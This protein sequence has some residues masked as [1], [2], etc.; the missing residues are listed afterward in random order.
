MS[1]LVEFAFEGHAVR[2]E[3]DERSE[4]LFNANDVCAVLEYG[5]P[6]DAIERHVDGDDVVKRDIID[7]L[8]RVQEANFLT[9]SGLYAIIF[10]SKLPAA[11]RFKRW[12]T[13]EVL[14]QIR[15]TGSQ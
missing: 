7:T 9:E 2:V 11:K 1:N 3:L 12:V 13:S 4:P 5:N 6:R 8:G 14:P 10:G 15:K